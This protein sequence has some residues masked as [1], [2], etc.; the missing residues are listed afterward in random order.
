MK[1]FVLVLT[2]LFMML[3]FAG[4][5]PNN[6]VVPDTRA[7]K[8]SVDQTG[9]KVS[10]KSVVGYVGDPMPF[11]DDGVMN[12]FYLQDGR[13]TRLG[14]HPFALMTTTD[15]VHYTD[16]GMVIPYE[17]SLYSQ[18]MALGTGSVIKDKDGLYHCYYTG[19]N[20]R[21]N[22]GLPYYEKIQHA[23][24]S[25][26][27]NWT[28]HPEDGFYGDNNDFR[29]PY[30]YLGEDNIYH[31]LITTRQSST[32]VIKEYSSE[33]LVE[34]KYE[35]IFFRNDAGSYNMECPTFIKYNGYYYLS[36]SEQGSTR[37]THYRYKK[38][39]SDDWIRPVNDYLD[40][41]GFYA[42]RMEK[43]NENRL[44]L[45]GWC[46]TRVGEYDTGNLDWGGNLIVHE[47]T[48]QSNGELKAKMLDTYKDTFKVEVA[49]NLKNGQSLDTM[50][51]SAD[52][53]NAYC[54]E[55]LSNNITRISFDIKITEVKG[56][57]GLSFNTNLTD[58]LSNEVLSFDLDGNKIAYYAKARSHSQLGSVDVYVPHRFARGDYHV[59]II[60]DGQIVTAYFNDEIALTTRFYDMPQNVFSFY[61][62]NAGIEYRNI[63]FYE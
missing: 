2:F 55:K 57:F 61:A 12:V 39:L 44:V 10:P 30:V 27:L 36:F 7:A 17:D 58:S 23:T 34:W 45:V 46:A 8:G 4:C 13:N 21:K 15:Y 63:K 3:A 48:Q 38:N 52:S 54:V 59:D 50:A 33:N 18:D 20:D 11:Y 9:L 31:M 60:I 47:L 41:E 28:K 32:G 5:Q 1:R 16:Y 56:S 6:P 24:S 26:K 14:F 53:F 43:E 49:Y 22:S 40:G 25:D 62:N 51:F 42:G 37:V 29:D 35:G 19:H